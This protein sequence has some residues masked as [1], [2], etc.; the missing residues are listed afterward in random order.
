MLNML[1]KL[2][3]VFGVVGG[4][5]AI[6][7]FLF[8]TSDTIQKKHE[9]N[10]VVGDY[11]EAMDDHKFQQAYDYFHPEQIKYQAP[12][13]EWEKQHESEKVR[14]IRIYHLETFDIQ[15]AKPKVEVGFL[16][17]DR[18]G[19]HCFKGTWILKEQYGDWKLF[20][21]ETKITKKRNCELSTLRSWIAKMNEIRFQGFSF[22][23]RA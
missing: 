18:S 11:Y 16:S 13:R 7:T 19:S 1:K 20:K 21:A 5:A 17:V 6:L 3:V 23:E 10:Q 9:V 14:V 4:V 8:V 2:V 12:F 22:F 15:E